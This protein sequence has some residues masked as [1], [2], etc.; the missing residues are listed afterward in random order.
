MKVKFMPQ[1]IE[2]EI[3]PDQTVLSLAQENKIEIR[4]VC[5]GMPS[6]AECRVRVVDGEYNVAPPSRKE[7]NLIGTGYFIDQRRLSCQLHCYGDV[8]IDL[9]EQIEMA[10]EGNVPKKF[11]ARAN[12]ERAE[13][14]NSVGGVLIE[15]D[16]ALLKQ[17]EAE[18]KTQGERRPPQQQRS[19][20]DQRSQGPRD[21]NGRNRE[22]APLHSQADS[23]ELQDNPHSHLNAPTTDGESAPDPGHHRPDGGGATPRQGEGG[24]RR[25]RGRGRGRGRRGRR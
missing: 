15:Q 16:D 10:K 9:T 18:A 21:R 12:K 8:T 7:L 23:R 14:Y 17:A 2:L 4:S 5:N 1:N 24:Q 13:D 22:P 25:G 6:C 11:L 19:R 3:R 20:Q